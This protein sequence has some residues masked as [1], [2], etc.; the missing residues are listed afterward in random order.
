M[1][2][3]AFHRDP[4]AESCTAHTMAAAPVPTS[5]V[6]EAARARYSV[7]HIEKIEIAALGT[8]SMNR[9]GLGVSAFHA[10]R[11]ACSIMS[12]GFS[13]HRY[14]DATVVMVPANDLASF[15][16]YNA[17]MAA[18]DERLPPASEKARFALLGKN[19]L[20]TA[21]RML[22]IGSFTVSGTGEP[23]MPPPGDAAL[24]VA[25]KEGIYCDV[26]GEAL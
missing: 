2:D 18:G 13:R 25:L 5:T 6:A 20:V 17:E 21:L 19:H 10:V 3:L 15:R 23:I 12:D 22:S 1:P 16:R 24:A 14:R 8:P 11:V 9:G 26:L 7:G 4:P